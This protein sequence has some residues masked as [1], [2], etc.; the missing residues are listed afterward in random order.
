MK[1]ATKLQTALLALAFSSIATGAMAQP[2]PA[3]PAAPSLPAGDAPAAT[4]P[5]PAAPSPSPSPPAAP[6]S[7]DASDGPVPEESRGPV[8]AFE[9]GPARTAPARKVAPARAAPPDS[10]TEY[11]VPEEPSGAAGMAGEEPAAEAPVEPPARPH[12]QYF[13]LGLGFR[14]GV[15]SNAGYDPYSEDNTLPAATL[16]GTFTPFSTRPASLHLA[17]EWDFGGASA[18]ARGLPSSLGMHRLALGLEGRYAPISRISF[19]ARAMPAAIRVSGTIDDTAL[20]NK[21]ET[22]S[23]TWGVDFTGGAAARIGAVGDRDR[24]KVSFWLALDMGYRFAGSTKMRFRPGDLTEDDQ[25]RSFGEIPLADLDL[26]GFISRLSG[27][28]SF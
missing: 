23:W 9:V 14:A 12:N 17:F 13:A 28:I 5:A 10:A 16:F 22:A 26:S 6:S 4:P 19:F 15:V 24:P 20:G 7:P 25:T 11:S 1:R 3:A 27:S 18:T 21:L 2:K 8:R